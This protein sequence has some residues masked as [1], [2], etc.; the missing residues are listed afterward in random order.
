[1]YIAVG[2]ES[3]IKITTIAS[4]KVVEFLFCFL[5]ECFV[6]CHKYKPYTDKHSTKSQNPQADTA[7]TVSVNVEKKVRINERSCAE[8]IED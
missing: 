1:M 8:V 2:S 4:T 5:S 7:Y 6:K 3:C